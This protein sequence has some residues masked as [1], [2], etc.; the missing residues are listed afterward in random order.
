[1]GRRLGLW[2]IWVGFVFGGRRLR[3]GFAAMPW[4]VQVWVGFA[5]RV[6]HLGLGHIRVKFVFGG[7]CWQ[8]DKRWGVVPVCKDLGGDWR[9]CENNRNKMKKEY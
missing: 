9:I 8:I 7:A 1:M 2:Q 5:F 4:L 6:R 3:L